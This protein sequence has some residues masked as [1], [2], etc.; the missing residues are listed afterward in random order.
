MT[1]G[2]KM[3]LSVPRVMAGLSRLNLLRYL[4]ALASRGMEAV[5]KFGLY[6][7]AARLMGGHESGLFFLCLTWVNL[8]STAARMG[9]E[10]AIARH[11]A[12]EL[13]IGHGSA[14]RRVL[15]VGLAWT[16]LAGVV[17][18][19]VT[20]LVASTASQLLFHEPDLRRPLQIAALVLLPQTLAF[21]IGFALIG[22]NRGV[23]AQII[24]SALPATLSLMALLVGFNR[25][26]T[27]LMSYAGSF[28]IC[29]VVGATL[30]LHEWRATMIDRPDTSGV[31]H[32][33]LP[34]LWTTARP[35]LV[36]ELTQS[37]LLSLPVLVLGMF[38]DAMIVSA[39]SI[40]SRLTMLINTILISVAMIVAPSFARHH[41]RLE[42]AAFQ[43]VNRQTKRIATFICLPLLAAM[44]IFPRHLLSLLGGEFVMA[45][46]ALEVLAL[47]QLVNVLLPTQDMILAMTGHGKTLLR[48][49]I[50]QLV[51]CCVLSAILIPTFRLMGAAVLSALILVQGRVSFALAVRRLL[52]EFTLPARQAQS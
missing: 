6:M 49:N 21:V 36:I 10:R 35:F 9:L 8:V 34:P 23:S 33:V 3:K 32:E 43:R 45:V 22:L 44:I 13:A 51:A 2:P 28:S 40:V 38:S 14:A 15:L 31:P 19:I 42:Y 25:I 20:I 17:A 29:C 47:A 48:L 24:Q 30:L 5:G 52:P 50:Q 1:T 41:R 16:T 26:D 39:F 4:G 37:S 11:I 18:A 7:L 12:A 46:G 27:L